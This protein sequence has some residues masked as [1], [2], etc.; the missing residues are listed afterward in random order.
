MKILHISGAMTMRGGEVQLLNLYRALQRKFVQQSVYCPSG[1]ELAA[2]CQSSGIICFTYKSASMIGLTAAMQLKKINT[3]ERFDL[4]HLHDSTAHTIGYMASLFGVRSPMV[5]SRKVVFR[6]KSSLLTQ[7]KYNADCI[8]KIICVSE[9]VRQL[10]ISSVKRNERVCL[11]HEGIEP[12]DTS[13][14]QQYTLPADVLSPHF[15]HLVGYVA[16][17]TEEKDHE[18][19]LQVA[20]KFVERGMNT[21]FLI[22]GSGKNELRIKRRID[23]LG[24]GKNVFML[25]YCDNVPGLMKQLDA[26][27]FTSLKEGLPVT[28]IESFFMKLPVVATNAGGIPELI[29]NDQ[30]GFISPVRDVEG[31]SQQLRSVLVDR[32]LR[33]RIISNAYDLAVHFT[34]DVMAE[35]MIAVYK[36]VI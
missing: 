33:E 28:I 31:L 12:P 8:K 7:L 36:E 17:L 19:F 1:S 22:A 16:A 15:D 27:L 13:S 25:G 4:L 26:L 3:K 35:K 5:L 32:L 23:E 18:T 10:V 6:I 9:A 2:Y 21:G 30:T 34:A 29:K 20:K 14:V 24:L 11:V